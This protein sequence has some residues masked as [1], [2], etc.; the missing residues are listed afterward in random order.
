MFGI[1]AILLVGIAVDFGG[2]VALQ[3]EVADV[4]RQ[5]ARAGGQPL[6]R[7]AAMQGRGGSLTPE[8]ASAAARE[9]LSGHDRVSGQVRV[10]DGT[11][12]QVDTR[13]TY[14]TK[15]LRIIGINELNASASAT[16][17][18]VTVQEGTEQ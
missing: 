5:S 18:M 13:A 8:R 4:A 12:I 2:R 11:T 9:Y 17:R 7:E 6:D 3:Q 1:S 16:S 10:I 14:E 15:F